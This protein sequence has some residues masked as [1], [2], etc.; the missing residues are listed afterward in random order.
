M[1][2]GARQRQERERLRRLAG[3]ERHGGDP[4]LQR[5]DALFQDVLRGVVDP[6]VDVAGLGQREEVGG[7]LGVLKTKEVDW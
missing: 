7:V 2:P 6:G 4:A 5:G 3:G 1:V